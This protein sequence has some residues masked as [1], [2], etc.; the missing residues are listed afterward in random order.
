MQDMEKRSLAVSVTCAKHDV[1]ADRPRD[2]E[3]DLN[4]VRRRDVHGASEFGVKGRGAW[5]RGSL[6]M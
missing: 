1:T 2:I 4:V 3:V 5:R 6:S